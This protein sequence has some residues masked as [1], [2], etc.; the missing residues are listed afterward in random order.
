MTTLRVMTFNV[1]GSSW[2]D[3]EN[4]WERRAALNVGTIRDTA[5][6]LV[7]FQE[8]Q[9]GNLEAYSRQLPELSLVLGNRY[10]NEEP[11][12]YA[13]IGWRSSTLRLLRWDSVFLGP[14]P[15]RAE[16]A[17]GAELVR[18]A[19][20]ARFAPRGG[21]AEFVHLNTHLDHESEQARLEGSRMLITLIDEL[22]SDGAPA[23]VTGD[24]NQSAHSEVYRLWA[25]AGFADAYLEAGNTEEGPTAHAFRGRNADM[26]EPDISGRI[27]W[28]LSRAGGAAEGQVRP[29]GRI[30]AC[31][32]DRTEQP[33]IYPSD[34]YPVVARYALPAA[35]TENGEVET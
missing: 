26:S 3:G 34:H 8:L 7:G 18:A 31:A 27:D 33:P 29:F 24:F 19:T 30:E 15:S 11:Y 9:R 25:D 2:P 4:T 35:A 14:D 6:H 13:A 22:Q 17:W 20:W 10:N 23:V 5:P 12:N 21:G 28:I 32:I 1:R 16:P